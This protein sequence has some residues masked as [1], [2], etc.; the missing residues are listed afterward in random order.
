M[1]TKNMKTK[2]PHPLAA[3]TNNDFGNRLRLPHGLATYLK[4]KG[5]E[6]RFVDAKM[7]EGNGNL[8]PWGWQV[9]KA[10]AA[11]F[12]DFSDT[13]NGMSPD[14]TVRR[15][16]LILGFR[17]TALGAQHRGIIAARNKA[18]RDVQRQHAEEL[19]SVARSAGIDAESAVTEG[20]ED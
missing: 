3:L 7:L 12:K 4:S 13:V 20:Y 6:F 10:N 16:T 18:Y 19:R 9:F 8:H 14:G 17:P 5:F 15:G 1:S 2:R 11:D